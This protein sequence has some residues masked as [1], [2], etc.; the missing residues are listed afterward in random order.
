MAASGRTADSA[1]LFNELDTPN[2]PIPIGDLDP[3]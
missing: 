2:L 3:I 1:M